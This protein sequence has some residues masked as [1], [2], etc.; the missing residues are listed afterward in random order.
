LD[1][2]EPLQIEVVARDADGREARTKF[3]VE[4]A[5]LR[6]ADSRQG[7]M[8]ADKSK[9]WVDGKPPRELAASFTDQVR[10]AKASRD[11]LLDKLA[12]SGPDK[13]GSGR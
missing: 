3:V 12:R 7:D 13:P 8:P 11:P 9:V 4:I 10:A 5:A 2:R 1:L 6:A